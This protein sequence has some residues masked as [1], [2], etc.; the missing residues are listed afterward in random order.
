MDELFS[1]ERLFA[2]SSSLDAKNKTN[3]FEFW[4]LLVVIR[5]KFHF[6]RALILLGR[7]LVHAEFTS[8]SWFGRC[9]ERHR[10]INDTNVIFVS[11]RNIRRTCV[12]Q[13]RLTPSKRFGKGM[14][15]T[16]SDYPAFSMCMQL[17]CVMTAESADAQINSLVQEEERRYYRSNANIVQ[18]RIENS[19]Q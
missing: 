16:Q 8:C 15:P 5:E 19:S 2:C 14:H 11:V 12:V 18:V 3:I 4:Y 17:Y 1:L 13:T 10:R 7:S 9:S 6:E